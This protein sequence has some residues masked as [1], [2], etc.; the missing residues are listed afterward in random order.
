M[1]WR[2]KMK[3]SKEMLREEN[4]LCTLENGREVFKG[5]KVYRTELKVTVTAEGMFIDG[6]GDTYLTF[7]EG[8]NAWISGPY[9]G[10]QLLR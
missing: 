5:D 9:N 1:N 4:Y 3:T 2:D 7:D 8:G 10:E 6:D